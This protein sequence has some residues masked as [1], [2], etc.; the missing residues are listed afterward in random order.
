MKPETATAIV[1][2]MLVAGSALCIGVRHSVAAGRDLHASPSAKSQADTRSPLNARGPDPASRPVASPDP[3]ARIKQLRIVLAISNE[4]DRTRALLDLISRFKAGDWPVALESLG[5]IG[6]ATGDVLMISAWTEADPQAAMAWAA[7]KRTEESMVLLA[8][9]GKDPDPA[10]AFLLSPDGRRS[11]NW[12]DLLIRALD[13]LGNDLPRVAQVIEATPE[14]LRAH[15]VSQA[16]AAS[17]ET[18]P[19]S[20]RAWI[21]SLD[22]SLKDHAL[23]LMMTKLPD[24]DAKLALARE[25]PE[26]IGP[27]KYVEIYDSWLK[28]DEAAALASFESLEAGPLHQAALIGIANG[29]AMK[30]K[31]PEAVALTNRWPEEVTDGMLADL[32]VGADPKH[33]ELVLGEIPRLKNETLRLAYYRSTLESWLQLDRAAANKWIQGNQIPEQLRRE[34]EDR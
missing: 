32:I 10:L 21:E 23:N 26:R 8:W 3:E 18:S 12:G 22:P 30:G 14:K 11:P 19:E 27:G 34:L 29:L 25:F 24:V 7:G 6:G 13:A 16:R 5:Q 28:A 15:V 31:L 20:V 4:A 1:V 33:A 17:G 9:F 2:S